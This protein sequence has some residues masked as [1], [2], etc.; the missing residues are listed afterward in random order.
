VGF[1]GAIVRVS[2]QCFRDLRRACSGK[3][4][5]VVNLLYNQ[6]APVNRLRLVLTTRKNMSS[7]ESPGGIQGRLEC[8][9]GETFGL[10]DPWGD[11][12]G[13]AV[14]NYPTG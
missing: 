12:R 11:N 13:Q 1:Q 7:A 14:L 5:L 6:T 4:I 2:P 9:S 8:R 3:N 10:L